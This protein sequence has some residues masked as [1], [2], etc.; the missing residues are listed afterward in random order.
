MDTTLQSRQLSVVDVDRDRR[1]KVRSKASMV[2][3]LLDQSEIDAK[4]P[5]RGRTVVV[6]LL[7]MVR[8]A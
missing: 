5:K 3:S 7:A 4:S 8:R 1:T 6:R 2:P